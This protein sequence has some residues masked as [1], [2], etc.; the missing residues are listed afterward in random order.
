MWKHLHLLMSVLSLMPFMASEGNEDPPE[1]D[2]NEGEKPDTPPTDRSQWTEKEWQ[3]EIQ[4]IAAKEKAD[5]RKAAE[6][7]YQQQQA[8]SQRKAELAKQ[9]AEGKYEEAKQQLGADLESAQRARDEALKLLKA[10][11]DTQWDELPDAVKKTYTGD[12][13]DVLAKSSHMNLMNPIIAE[14]AEKEAAQ[15]PGNRPNPNPAD[16][17]F[18]LEA[19]TK[20]ARKR[21]NIRF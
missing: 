7:E 3:A 20:E 9:E 11:V 18:D 21:A 14:L 1:S 16:G 2:S 6:R 17:K 13:D 12:E 15:A 8:E 19:A 4:R 10:N 5:G